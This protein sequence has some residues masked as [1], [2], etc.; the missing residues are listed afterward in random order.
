MSD[1]IE[2]SQGKTPSKKRRATHQI[3]EEDE[4]SDRSIK[5]QK[6]PRKSTK[7]RMSMIPVLASPAD[8]IIT[9]TPSR[10]RRS[11]APPSTY[12][13]SALSKCSMSP[14]K[15]DTATSETPARSQAFLPRAGLSTAG[16]GLHLTVR[17][18]THHLSRKA[19]LERTGRRGLE[20]ANTSDISA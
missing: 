15:T 19:G 14:T 11:R 18:R 10:T 20:A 2:S 4:E 13:M 5:R 16:L 6:S 1:I 3:D 12:N 7:P 9:A 8:S 17:V